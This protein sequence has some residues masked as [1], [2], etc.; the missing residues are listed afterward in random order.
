MKV[1]WF[2]SVRFTNDWEL[3]FIG[4]VWNFRVGRTQLTLWRNY[5]PVFSFFRR[6]P[7]GAWHDPVM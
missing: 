5:N 1:R 4:K 3:N 2:R 6:H 7:G